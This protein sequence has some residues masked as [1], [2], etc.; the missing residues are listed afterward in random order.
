[1][2]IAVRDHESLVIVTYAIKIAYNRFYD[3]GNLL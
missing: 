3:H 1:M 2:D